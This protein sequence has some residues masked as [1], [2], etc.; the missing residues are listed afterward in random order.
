MILNSEMLQ[1]RLNW[2]HATR[3]FDPAGCDEILGL[4]AKGDS[5]VCARALGYRAA[6]DPYA[7][8]KKVRYEFSEI[9]EQR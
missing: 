9:S 8:A 3:K 2:R 5:T 7:T 4:A 1:T 6:D